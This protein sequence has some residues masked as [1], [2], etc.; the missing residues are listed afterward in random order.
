MKFA[1]VIKSQSHMIRLMNS[2]IFS[3]FYITTST[4]KTI[5]LAFI[6]YIVPTIKITSIKARTLPTTI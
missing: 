6:I 5:Y 4:I 2:I 1:V 3:I